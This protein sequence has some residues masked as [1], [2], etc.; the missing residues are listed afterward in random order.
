MK[1]FARAVSIQCR[2]LG[3]ENSK[4]HRL[5]VTEENDVLVWDVAAGRFTADGSLTEGTKRRA[6]EAPFQAR[7]PSCSPHDRHIHTP[8]RGYYM[9][10]ACMKLHTDAE[11]IDAATKVVDK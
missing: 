8:H 6:R 9:C 3:E 4:E 11:M 1:T 2:V 10:A 5:A 7:C